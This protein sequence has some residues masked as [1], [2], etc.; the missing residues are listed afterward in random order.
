MAINTFSE[1]STYLSIC[2]QGGSFV[3]FKAIIET[4]DVPGS[5]KGMEG[6]PTIAGGRLK[7]FAPQEDQEVTL[8][9]YAIEV[10]SDGTTGNGFYDLMGTVDTS[11]PLSISN[12]HT[13]DDFELVVL[14]T[15]NTSQTTATAAT[16]DGDKAMRW[17]FK[18]GNF[19]KV[20]A[21]F[22]DGVWKFTIT[23][24]IPAFDK[25]A[26]STSTVE[27]T[28]GTSSAILAAISDYS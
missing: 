5:E 27:S 7:K 14:A 23:Y 26:S 11:Q 17:D 20:D 8:E 15:D 12:D 10:G 4:V 1:G 9:G 3:D 13:H 21:S 6:I 22:T 2:K 25:A 16:T 18:G 28:D 24:K 19:T